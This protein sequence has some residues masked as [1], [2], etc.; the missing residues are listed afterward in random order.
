MAAES[1]GRPFNF[2]RPRIARRASNCH[3]P[4]GLKC[5]DSERLTYCNPIPTP[6]PLRQGPTKMAR[7]RRR[8]QRPH[9]GDS[10]RDIPADASGSRRRRSQRRRQPPQQHVPSLLL[11]HFPLALALLLT[12]ATPAAA[13]ITPPQ[14]R[15]QSAPSPSFQRPRV[16]T[17]TGTALR[18]TTTSTSTASSSADN[19]SSSPHPP[20]AGAPSSLLRVRRATR[21]DLR[22]VATMQVMEYGGE[23]LAFLW[24]YLQV[25]EV[26][27]VCTLLSATVS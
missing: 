4:L 13:F 5:C 12:P 7:P 22:R 20:T 26:C 19:D 1:I 27:D 17:T 21:A 14:K 9:S 8:Q 10:S 16:A 23:G 25:C 15:P 24:H 3:H 6:I 11:L 2:D 18:A